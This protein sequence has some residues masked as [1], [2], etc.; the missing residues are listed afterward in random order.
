MKI[1]EK[2]LRKIIREALSTEVPDIRPRRKSSFQVKK[3]KE[4]AAKVASGTKLKTSESLTT[5]EQFKQLQPGDRLSFNGRV[6]VVFRVDP[7][8]AAVE[9]V[10]QGKA[11]R[12]YFDYRM[13]LVYEPGELPEYDVMYL[14]PGSAP[15]NT[16]LSR[17]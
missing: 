12:K 1:T 15:E 17:R 4:L 2:K 11:S 9:Y 3:E 16:R 7:M 6:I 10:E 14:G 13:A 8:V 5:P